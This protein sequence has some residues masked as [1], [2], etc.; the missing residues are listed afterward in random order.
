MIAKAAL[1]ATAGVALIGALWW[2][3]K[4]VPAAAPAPAPVAVVATGVVPDA[5]AGLPVSSDPP[6]AIAERVFELALKK[7]RLVSGPA[8]LEA[9]EGDHIV[10]EIVSD[11]DSGDELHLHGYDLRARI[12]PD[13]AVRLAFTANRTGR[14]GL[15]LHRAHAELGALE[16]YPR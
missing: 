11:S 10:L 8:R 9:R 15:E 13:R 4:P 2:A 5:R 16:V 1:F 6:A 3:F 14:F 12:T 7:G